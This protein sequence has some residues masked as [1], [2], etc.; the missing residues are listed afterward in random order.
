[1]NR[2]DQ[3]VTAVRT[4][5]KRKP[6][7]WCVGRIESAL[8]VG[9]APDLQVALI[10]CRVAVG[11]VV[12]DERQRGAALHE[13]QRIGAGGHDETRA[14]N[15]VPRERGGPCLTQ[16]V[17]IERTREGQ[18]QLI[19]VE[20]VAAVHQRV[21]QQ[22]LLQ[23]RGRVEILDVRGV[24][25]Q[26]VERGLIESREREVGGIERD[27]ALH[28]A[29]S[30]RGELRLEIGCERLSDI[31]RDLRRV[32]AQGGCQ[33]A[34][35]HPRIDIERVLERRVVG[36]RGAERLVEREREQARE[37][38]GLRQALIEAAEIVEADLRPGERFGETFAHVVPVYAACRN[39]AQGAGRRDERVASQI[40]PCRIARGEPADRAAR[41]VRGATAFMRACLHVLRIAAV[42]FAAMAF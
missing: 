37:C 4:R 18:P 33:A 27:V 19:D 42:K 1:M 36:D 15:I 9:V 22:S 38:A 41:V 11:P 7:E 13:L 3:I 32:V 28:A 39:G 8:T 35:R 25:P 29:R 40:E 34:I 26:C 6:Q 24:E 5:E 23:G 16:R 30:E 10:L 14:Q 21:E 17:A 12:F 20:A 31:R 2:A